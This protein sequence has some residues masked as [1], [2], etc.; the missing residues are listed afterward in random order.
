MQ[1]AHL[2]LVDLGKVHKFAFL[3]STLDAPRD[4][5]LNDVA[6]RKHSIDCRYLFRN[7]Q[8]GQDLAFGINKVLTWERFH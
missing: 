7:N 2:Y 8:L 3:T 1:I 6:W 4:H 5:F